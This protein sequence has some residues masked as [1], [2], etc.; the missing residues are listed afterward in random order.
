MKSLEME[1]RSYIIIFSSVFLLAFL[2][3]C[4]TI[5]TRPLDT[6]LT[7]TVV[8]AEPKADK[9]IPV[10]S[11]LPNTTGIQQTTK[12][13]LCGPMDDIIQKMLKEYKEEPIVIWQDS[14]QGYPVVLLINKQTQTSTVLEYPGILGDLVLHNQACIV[15]VGVNTQIVDLPSMK[16][17]IRLL[18]K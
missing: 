13:V 8:K 14:T 12:P 16:T 3:G 11:L 1:I 7:K 18:Q 6:P 2:S 17:H 4:Q 15:S 10:P 9:K 5:D